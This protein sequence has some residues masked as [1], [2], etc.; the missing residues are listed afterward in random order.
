MPG[1]IVAD[2]F[3]HVLSSP[4]PPACVE[5]AHDAE[6]VN[7]SPGRDYIEYIRILNRRTALSQTVFAREDVLAAALRHEANGEVR[8]EVESWLSP[9]RRRELLATF[10]PGNAAIA[11]EFCGRRDERLFEEGQPDGDQHWSPYEGLTAERATAISLAIHAAAL[12]HQEG[13]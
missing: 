7:R 12:S 10:A 11:R 2:F 5:P 3:E 6:S 8:G 13:A 4:V 1:G 9:A